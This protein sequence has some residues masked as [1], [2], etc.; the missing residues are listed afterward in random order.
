MPTEATDQSLSILIH[1]LSKSGKSTLAVTAPAPRLY[2]DVESASR[3]LDV[4]RVIWNPHTEAPP[5][6][7]GS[8]DTCVVPTRSWED[9]LA[10]YQWLNSGAHPFDSVIIDS[11]SELQ[12]RFI[13]KVGGRSQLTMQQWGDAFRQVVGLCRDIRDLTM[14]PTHPLKCIAL[15]AMTKNVDGMW[16]PYVS[17]QLQTVLPYLWD[18]NSYLYVEQVRDLDGGVTEVRRLLTRRSG[19]FEA[20]ERV[21][22]KIPPVV[23]NPNITEMIRAI[24]GTPLPA[25]EV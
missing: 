20:G 2:L 23:D 19:D 1:G 18:I 13:E 22:G 8:W 5:T 24:F 11:I 14:H 6:Y 9:V 7:D 25:P 15:T 21:G 17:G 12:S 3:F 16:K 10:V 4:K